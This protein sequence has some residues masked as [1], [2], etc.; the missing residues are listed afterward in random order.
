[1]NSERRFGTRTTKENILLTDSTA[2][3]LQES[4]TNMK[5]QALSSPISSQSRQRVKS[6][7]AEDI[8]F[9]SPLNTILASLDCPPHESCH[10]S[11]HDLI[12]AYSTLTLGLRADIINDSNNDLNGLGLP[13][14]RQASSFV[15][16]VRRDS[17]GVLYGPGLDAQADRPVLSEGEVQSAW[18]IATLSHYALRLV[19]VIFAFPRLHSLFT[20]KHL[21]S[22]FDDVLTILLTQCLPTPN[23]SRTHGLLLWT[24][25]VQKLDTSIITVRQ[26]E[27]ILQV[28]DL[29]LRGV[30][31][32]NQS[33][34][35]G[36]R[37]IAGFLRTSQNELQQ[38][39]R[40][41]CH[42][43]DKVLSF[44]A[45]TTPA[46]R[47]YATNVLSAFAYAKINQTLDSELDL[48]L[49]DELR[50][51]LRLQSS[52]TTNSDIN[53]LYFLEQA[54]LP[55][56]VR[57][58]GAQWAVVTIASIIILLDGSTFETGWAAKTVQMLGFA[59][60]MLTVEALIPLIWNCL[61]WSFS[62]IPADQRGGSGALGF[63][64][65]ECRRGNGNALAALL[66][67]IPPGN[68]PD[69]DRVLL[70][71]LRVVDIMVSHEDAFTRRDGLK[72]LY[73]LL[74][75]ND[76]G[77]CPSDDNNLTSL[78]NPILFDGTLL[79]A[80]SRS[81]EGLVQKNP[82]DATIAR[83]LTEVEVQQ[84]WDKLLEIWNKSLLT[85][86]ENPE[87]DIPEIFF[88]IWQFLL[89]NHSQL[90]Q[91]HCH[92]TA[93]NAFV[94]EASDII[95]RLVNHRL[96]STAVPQ[97]LLVVQHLWDTLHRVFPSQA[98]VQTSRIL[99]EAVI[100]R[101]FSIEDEV[102]LSQWIILCHA[103]CSNRQADRRLDFSESWVVIASIVQ[104]S[105]YSPDRLVA[106]LR[107]PL[108]L[109]FVTEDYIQS[110]CDLIRG[111]PMTSCQASQAITPSVTAF[112]R[113]L[114]PEGCYSPSSYPHLVYCIFQSID[115][116]AAPISS[117]DRQLLQ[118]ILSALNPVYFSADAR[119]VVLPLKYVAL[120]NRLISAT[121]D[122][123]LVATLTFFSEFLTAWN[124]DKSK[125]VAD[126]D[127]N[128]AIVPVYCTI[129]ERLSTFEASITILK[130]LGALLISPLERC[131]HPGEATQAF[132]K[133]WTEK[134]HHRTAELC[135]YYSEDLKEA[136][137]C[138]DVVF[139]AGFSEVFSLSTDSQ[140]ED[141]SFIVPESVPTP[142]PR[143]PVNRARPQRLLTTTPRSPILHDSDNQNTHAY[144]RNAESST[145][146]S[147]RKTKEATSNQK[148]APASANRKKR[149]AIVMDCV[150]LSRPKRTATQETKRS[151]ESQ[152]MTP[153]PSRC[154]SASPFRSRLLAEPDTELDSDNYDWDNGN[155]SITD[156]KE[157]LG[158]DDGQ[159]PKQFPE[160]EEAPPATVSRPSKRRRLQDSQSD[161]VISTSMRP[162]PNDGARSMSN[163][164]MF[165]S[166]LERL[167]QSFNKDTISVPELLHAQRLIHSFGASISQ[168]LEKQIGG[169]GLN[170]S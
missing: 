97:H 27:K 2:I 35:D 66:R 41:L 161:T 139:R 119:L 127:Y 67:C 81:L 88:G 96:D 76:P 137:R 32:G 140:T 30:Y 124:Q 146:S 55:G 51:F 64:N 145:H 9:H 75:G 5:N 108:T 162:V 17:K 11:F 93:T 77:T 101:N 150:Q 33:T 131:P 149:K 92:L 133:F 107:L 169:N 136:L 23:A 166:E 48:L 18:N 24:L 73:M 40:G 154:S 46:E 134:Y 158:V 59:H 8:V 16:V 168:A 122:E 54:L 63:L 70:K 142:S 105:N 47:F 13:S 100:K 155:V 135:T 58:E 49:R 118:Q 56:K 95:L 52:V 111:T 148:C 90:T 89:L 34:T 14:K 39:Q 44:L 37:A 60:R 15:C 82:V 129:L 74:D 29:V 42:H 36:L 57:F 116:L 102:T 141:G 61:I 106:F 10:I 147:K 6:E 114:W 115:K 151:R 153:E 25:G 109:S 123:Y 132:M 50:S 1:M 31:K 126:D 4:S 159:V 22:L 94:N 69:P 128:R 26:E 130:E 167:R 45:S 43:F 53:L 72:L 125:I 19:S 138:L 80:K 79:N 65:Q 7:P 86:L 21:S 28:I 91:H 98:L 163:G 103:L 113:Q 71:V 121:P 78:L 144:D 99:L 157:M 143:R 3:Y 38:L 165:V 170:A 112:W 68:S 87:P 85:T 84:Y 164:S 117:E 104:Q 62:R 110:W 20:V 83:R 152:L 12:D 120:A 156:V 160:L